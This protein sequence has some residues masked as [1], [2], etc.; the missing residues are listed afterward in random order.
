MITYSKELTIRL[1]VNFTEDEFKKMIDKYKKDCEEWYIDPSD[2][3][4]LQIYLDENYAWDLNE[5]TVRDSDSNI[6]EVHCNAQKF[7]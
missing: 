7:L 6:C 2:I 1:N 4:N 3:D 5:Y